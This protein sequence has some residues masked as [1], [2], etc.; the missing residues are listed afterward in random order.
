M[1]WEE[2]AGRCAPTGMVGFEKRA[3]TRPA[4]TA[5]GKAGGLQEL[6]DLKL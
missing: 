2:G 6:I 5:G 1:D 4:P 3:G